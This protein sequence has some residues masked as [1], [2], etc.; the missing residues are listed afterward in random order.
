MVQKLNVELFT[1][2]KRQK[3][4]GLSTVTFKQ[5]VSHI[6]AAILVS[7]KKRIK[8]NKERK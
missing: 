5:I 2:I 3:Q 4:L 1:I 8:V 7:N 6:Q